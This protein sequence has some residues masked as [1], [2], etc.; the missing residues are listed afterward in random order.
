MQSS[1]HKLK[2]DVARYLTVFS[3]SKKI[4]NKPRILRP[5][6]IGVAA[7]AYCDAWRSIRQDPYFSGC[8]RRYFA[9]PLEIT[10]AR[11]QHD[12][13]RTTDIDAIT[14]AREETWTMSRLS[15]LQKAMQDSGRAGRS[16]R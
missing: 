6:G 5:S 1:K 15:N 8:G 2:G 9:E 11:S 12:L 4:N 7:C 16:H 10:L 3:Q 14:V 13:D